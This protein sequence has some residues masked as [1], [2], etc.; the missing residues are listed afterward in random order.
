METKYW[1]VEYKYSDGR[2]GKVY[3]TT[4]VSK[5]ESFEYGNGKSGLLTV[6]GIDWGY[7]LRYSLED[8]LHLAMI[9]DFFGSG[10]TSAYEERFLV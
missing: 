5:S 4:I 1:I 3:V 10:F 6:D 2:H 7:D 8:D 9:K